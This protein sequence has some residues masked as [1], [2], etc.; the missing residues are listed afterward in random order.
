MVAANKMDEPAAEENLK[1]FEKKCLHKVYP[2][3]CVSD[4][5]FKVLVQA[6]LKTVLSV[7]EAEN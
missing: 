6:L 2:I 5:G 7:R 1:H 4:E 3:S